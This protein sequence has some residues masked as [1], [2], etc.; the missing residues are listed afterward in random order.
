MPAQ[1]RDTA[2]NVDDLWDGD[3]TAVSVDGEAVLLVSIDGDLRAYSNR[4]PHQGSALD[5]TAP[6]SSAQSTCGSSTLSAAVAS[7]RTVTA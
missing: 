3:M 2:M 5:S 6:R 1:W 7:I 4:C